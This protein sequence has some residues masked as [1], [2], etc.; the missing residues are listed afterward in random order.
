VHTGATILDRYGL[1]TE[2]AVRRAKLG[3]IHLI[4]SRGPSPER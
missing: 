3:E 2:L 4:L 1:G